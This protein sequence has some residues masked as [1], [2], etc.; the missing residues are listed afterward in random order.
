ARL[1]HHK[2]TR[3]AIRLLSAKRHLD[4]LQH[5]CDG[6][7]LKSLT[8]TTK[9]AIFNSKVSRIFIIEN[10]EPVNQVQLNGIYDESQSC[11]PFQ[12]FGFESEN[13]QKTWEI[14]ICNDLLGKDVQG[15]SSI[16]SQRDFESSI[17]RKSLF[18][19]GVAIDRNMKAPKRR[20]LSIYEENDLLTQSSLNQQPHI[21]IGKHIAP[22]E[23]YQQARNDESWKTPILAAATTIFATGLQNALQMS[24]QH[25]QDNQ[26]KKYAEYE[27]RQEQETVIKLIQM[28]EGFCGME[29]KNFD[30]KSV[31]ISPMERQI[32]VS[33]VWL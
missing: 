22:T 18:N 17:T 16:V 21:N 14:I 6:M 4:P 12:R 26:F 7:K 29:F 31:V 3:V 19:S 23:V 5:S 27:S 24:F 8:L 20:R 11:I 15:M 2:A 32:L 33:K 30:P 25:Q 28:L 10:D 9:L 1:S 13:H